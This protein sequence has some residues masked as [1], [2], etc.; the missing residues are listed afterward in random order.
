MLIFQTKESSKSSHKK[1][2]AV[3]DLDKP[4]IIDINNLGYTWWV[5]YLSFCCLRLVVNKKN[6]VFKSVTNVKNNI[7]LSFNCCNLVLIFVIY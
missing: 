4:N 5:G 3:V 7:N 1:Q 2:Q 6:I